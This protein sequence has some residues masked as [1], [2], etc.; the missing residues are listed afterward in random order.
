MNACLCST[1]PLER[2]GRAGADMMIRIVKYNDVWFGIYT[3]C[4]TLAEWLNEINA[5]AG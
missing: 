1:W 3:A 4:A 5:N 2:Y